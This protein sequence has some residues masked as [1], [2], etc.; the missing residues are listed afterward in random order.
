[1]KPSC[2]DR[3]GVFGSILLALS[4]C[5]SWGGCDVG[6]DDPCACCGP[7]V[8]EEALTDDPSV[9][10]GF[11]YT[12][13]DILATGVGSW[14][15][16]FSLGGNE[17]EFVL[18]TVY[19]WNEESSLPNF[20]YDSCG[21]LEDIGTCD[22]AAWKGIRLAGTFDSS[23]ERLEYDGYM[24]VAATGFHLDCP[25]ISSASESEF[26]G[27]IRASFEV[28][29]DGCDVRVVWAADGQMAVVVKDPT[30][31]EWSPVQLLD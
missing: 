15:G 18:T 4:L 1:M 23:D 22:P 17:V 14:H 30:G 16:R 24:S 5:A 31:E 9:E 25:S 26:C 3:S 10:H 29:D 2:Q 20:G 21:K 8:S 12:F 13:G 7:P 28:S 19:E 6:E 11:T 27:C